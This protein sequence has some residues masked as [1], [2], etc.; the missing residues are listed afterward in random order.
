MS[1][2]FS[3]FFHKKQLREYEPWLRRRVTRPAGLFRYYIGRAEEFNTIH[4][5]R[6]IQLIANKTSV[7]KNGRQIWACINIHCPVN[8][9]VYEP[10]FRS[11]LSI[12]H[13]DDRKRVRFWIVVV[14]WELLTMDK[15]QKSLQRTYQTYQHALLSYLLTPWCR[16]LL[17]KLTGLQ[18]VKKFPAFYGTQRFITALTS[19]RQLSLSWASFIQSTHLHPTSRRSI[20]ILSSHLRLGLPSGYLPSGFPTKTLYTSLPSAIRATCSAHLILLDFITRTILGQEYR[21][22]K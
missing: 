15:A 11:H 13:S 3:R 12:L 6:K 9:C 14:F 19:A 20:L 22:F 17:G 2:E 10:H 8:T 5:S 7:L 4:Q 21:S 16:V 18:L 1:T